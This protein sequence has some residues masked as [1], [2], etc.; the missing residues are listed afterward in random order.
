MQSYLV[1]LSMQTRL[2]NSVIIVNRGIDHTKNKFFHTKLFRITKT[3]TT[4]I[5]WLGLTKFRGKK[6]VTLP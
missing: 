4:E 6:L 3:K 1:K 5:T 2:G